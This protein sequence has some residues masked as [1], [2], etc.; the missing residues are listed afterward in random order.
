MGRSSS[1]SRSPRREPTVTETT[2]RKALNV[3]MMSLLKKCE[4]GDYKLYDAH[5][6][7]FRSDTKG[8]LGLRATCKDLAEHDAEAWMSNMIFCTAENIQE[9]RIADPEGP[10]A[11]EAREDMERCMMRDMQAEDW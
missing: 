1:R 6:S 10:W 5:V 8:I 4:E 9:S 3:V 11:I 7:E 2:K